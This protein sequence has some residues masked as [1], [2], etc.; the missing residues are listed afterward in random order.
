MSENKAN[1]SLLRALSR[2]TLA[3]KILIKYTYTHEASN[4]FFFVDK[5]LVNSMATDVTL[6]LSFCRTDIN[7]NKH[8]SI[9]TMAIDKTDGVKSF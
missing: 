7:I 3:L 4:Y 1:S 6:S 2:K 5:V 9:V 8:V